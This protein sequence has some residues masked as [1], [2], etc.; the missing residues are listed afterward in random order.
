MLVI[1]DLHLFSPLLTSN[2][3]KLKLLKIKIK[4]TCE[5]TP[6]EKTYDRRT[7]KQTWKGEGITNVE[8]N[9]NG[10][11]QEEVVGMEPSW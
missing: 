5:N 9:F 2:R 8:N 11:M 4:T 1:V 7:R 3:D 10:G 6:L